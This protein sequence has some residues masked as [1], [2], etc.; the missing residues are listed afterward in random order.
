[1]LGALQGVSVLLLPLLVRATTSSHIVVSHGSASLIGVRFSQTR[2][3]TKRDIARCKELGVKVYAKH[4]LLIVAPSESPCSRLAVAVTTKLDK[5]ATRRNTTKRR[6]REIFREVLHKFSTTVD[7]L[8]VARNG[9]LE[10]SFA[11]ARHEILS[12][13]C[14]KGFLAKSVLKPSSDQKDRGDAH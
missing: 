14:S 11:T 6:L 13:L 1:M 12:A 4:F 9:S 5:R 8:A 10:C 7:I 3:R 2:L